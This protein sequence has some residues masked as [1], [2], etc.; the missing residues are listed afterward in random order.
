MDYDGPAE[1]RW[2]A[3]GSL[4]IVGPV[5]VAVTALDP[6][7]RV[8]LLAPTFDEW[9]LLLAFDSPFRLVFPDSSSFDVGIGRPDPDGY[10]DAWDWSVDDQHTDPCPHCGA[11]ARHVS[12]N[13]NGDESITVLD[14]CLGC[15]RERRQEY[16]WPVTSEMPGEHD[17]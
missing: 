16:R 12:V 7:W 4:S 8:R 17:S 10:F 9:W 6:G 1:I 3:S 11:V 5:Q 15:T 13:D 14:R 2:Q